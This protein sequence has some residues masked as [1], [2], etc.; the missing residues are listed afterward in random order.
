MGTTWDARLGMRLRYV[1]PRT[2]D[3]SPE[4]VVSLDSHRDL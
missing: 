4:S 3:G 1:E 2:D